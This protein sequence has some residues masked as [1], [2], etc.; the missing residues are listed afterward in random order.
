MF[1]GTQM[2]YDV[3]Y[4]PEFKATTTAK[5]VKD[6]VA[7]HNATMAQ[8]PQYKVILPQYMYKP[9]WGFPRYQPLGLLRELG[10]NVYAS[11]VFKSIKDIIID[12]P[13]Q[14]VLK[15]GV[16]MT[17]ELQES[18]DKN[19]LFFERPNPEETF[20]I[21]TRKF[22]DDV[23]KFDSGIIN[24][25]YNPFGELIQLRAAPGDT[26][27]KNP[28]KHGYMDERVDIIPEKEPNN[29]LVQEAKN[30]RNLD[31]GFANSSAFQFYT[32]FIDSAAYFQFVNNVASKIPIPFGKKEI[33]W[34]SMNPSTDN[35]YTNGSALEDSIDLILSLVYGLKFNLDFYMNGNTPEGIINAVG[36]TKKDLTKIKDQLAHSINTP[37]DQFGMKRRVGYRMPVVNMDNLDFVKLN[38]TSKEMEILEQQKWFT[39]V[40]WMRFGLNADEMGF[41]E[42]SNRATG[43]QQGKNSIRKAIKPIYVMIEEAFNYDILPELENGELMRWEFDFYD[44]VE[45]K[46]VRDL[47]QQEIAMGINSAR[48]I[49]EKEGID[50]DEIE[51]HHQ[52]AQE[53]E[54][55][56]KKPDVPEEN[57]PF[58]GKDDKNLNKEK[59]KP[60]T[61]SMTAEIGGVG[62]TDSVMNPVHLEKLTIVKR[63]GKWE[64]EKAEI[65]ADEEPIKEIIKDE[66]GKIE[67]P[68][69]K[70]MNVLAERIAERNDEVVEDLE[71]TG[72]S[73]GDAELKHGKGEEF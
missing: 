45:Q 34:L 14:I 41:T 1:G 68:L 55:D 38:M 73:V 67:T 71:P 42:D 57:S 28:N 31:N 53:F 62:T 44:P 8:N 70:V 11:S 26:F 65:K 13:R 33:C 27:K 59:K 12:T 54:F 51:S 18:I 49:M 46:T 47:Q 36:A 37:K 16:E 21:L 29:A 56:L 61:K 24:K 60:E 25:V 63:N 30:T 2:E 43:V 66:V 23:F 4:E 17:P 39:K 10:K 22:L 50:A 7:E 6:N 58:D 3:I 35:V 48:S 20:S 72:N 40:L 52:D 9:A 32:N 5:D 64:M 19:M 69:E 15:K